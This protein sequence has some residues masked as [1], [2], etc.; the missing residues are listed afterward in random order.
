MKRNRTEGNLAGVRDGL[1]FGGTPVRPAAGYGP[2]ARGSGNFF[3]HGNP[4]GGFRH[5][6]MNRSAARGYG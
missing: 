3:R 1:G 4:S 5:V 6:V 2:A